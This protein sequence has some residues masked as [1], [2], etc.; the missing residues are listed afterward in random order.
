[1]KELVSIIMPS[2]NSEHTIDKSI[3]S[4]MNQ[5]YTNWELIIVDDCSK[6]NTLSVLGKYKNDERIIISSNECNS[7]AAATRN[8]ALDLAS[9]R[10]VAFL[11][12]DD[13]WLPEKL[14][15][16]MN[17]MKENSVGFVF[18]SYRCINENGKDIDRIIKVPP[19]ISAMKLLGNTIIGCST[20]L[21]DRKVVGNFRFITN[22]RREDTF[23]WYH[24]LK[25]GYNAYGIQEILA[26][27]RISSSSSSSNKFEMAMEYWRG[28]KEVAKI[29]FLKRSYCFVSYTFN[30]FKKRM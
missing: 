4:V 19:V 24:I 20:V 8:N 30:A 3:E 14:E 18:S 12:S 2:Y 5:T 1:M 16:Q 7:R 21:V 23:T 22:N 10:Y 6:D 17:F 25:R 28:L 11:D 13:L 9:G 26:E 29:D 15:K 27:Y